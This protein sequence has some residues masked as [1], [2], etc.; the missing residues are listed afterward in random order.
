[1]VRWMPCP[2][3]SGRAT[4]NPRACP[5]PL[6]GGGLIAERPLTDWALWTQEGSDDKW[7]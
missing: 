1:M 6:A 7:G 2:S 3:T 5:L 4:A